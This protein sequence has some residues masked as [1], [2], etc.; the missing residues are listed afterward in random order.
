M[1]GEE[2]Y[3]AAFDRSVKALSKRPALGQGTSVTR[4]RVREGLVCEIEDGKWKLTADLSEK[5]GGT[6]AGPDPGVLGRSALASCLAMAY[7]LWAARLEVPVEGLE[8]EVQAD[9]DVRGQYGLGDLRPG[10]REVR[11]VV[12]ITSPASEEAIHQLVEQAEEH[13]PYLDV[14]ARPQ[15]MRRELRILQPAG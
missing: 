6:G 14:F 8:V 9:Y 5:G 2:R 3:R 13:C 7:L 15:E 4:A 1:R 12:S 10:Y 11:Y